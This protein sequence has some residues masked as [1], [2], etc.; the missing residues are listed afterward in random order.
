[1]RLLVARAVFDTLAA[2]RHRLPLIGG[3]SCD[4]RF[5]G[6]NKPDPSFEASVER[7]TGSPMGLP[8]RFLMR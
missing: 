6:L 3:S 2:P 7:L 4:A 8:V 1:M 5:V